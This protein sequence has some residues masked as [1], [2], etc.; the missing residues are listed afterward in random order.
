MIDPFPFV[1][2]S[3]FF[4]FLEL[5]YA[6]VGVD[7]AR[8]LCSLMLHEIYVCGRRNSCDLMCQIIVLNHIIW[9]VFYVVLKVCN[10]MFLVFLHQFLEL[11]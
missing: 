3:F 5:L 10:F 4:F 7:F 8:N 11:S 2:P 9:G 1:S 6:L